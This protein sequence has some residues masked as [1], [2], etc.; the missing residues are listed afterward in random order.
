MGDAVEAGCYWP[1]KHRQAR[2]GSNV[3]E[4]AGRLA[5][6]NT[7]RL[8]FPREPQLAPREGWPRGATVQKL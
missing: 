2:H 4:G 7:R 1:G 8:A 6:H 5:G 3:Q